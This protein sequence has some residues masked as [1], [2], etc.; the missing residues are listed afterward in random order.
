M[1]VKLENENISV[2]ISELGAELTSVT[3]RESG[4]EY[5][6][7]ADP[8]FWGRH[9]PNLFPIVG[10]LK[11]DRYKYRDKTYFMTQHGFARDNEFDLVEKTAT[12]ARLRLVDT[13]ETHSIYPFHFQFD[14]IYR[15]T[16]QDTL[17]VTYVVTNTDSH[18]IYFSVG[19]HPGFRVPLAENEKF[20]DYYV[21]VEPNRIYNRSKLVGPYLDNNLDTTF[22]SSIPL[23]LRRDDYKNDAIILRLDGNPVSVVL[24]RLGESNGV[25][26]HIQDAQYVG[27]WTPYGKE[28][29]F[30]C[31]EPWW[32]VADTVDA[33]GIINHK[34][35]INELAPAQTFT[36]SY[37]LSFF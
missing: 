17:G 27:I 34:Y 14:V 15:L 3:N 23:R 30:V 12:Y 18:E 28:A 33:D 11:G 6:W 19:G 26:M 36:G 4:L 31:L 22:N 35:G 8:N 21:N 10:R 37:S 9:A 5:M 1:S 7:T 2:I 24:A 13:E 16:D 29:P 20:T 32:G 25:T